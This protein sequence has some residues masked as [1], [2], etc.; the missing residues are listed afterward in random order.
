MALPP[1]SIDDALAEAER[2]CAAGADKEAAAVYKAILEKF[3]QDKRARAGLAA[4]LQRREG[5]DA[6]SNELNTL[7][8]LFNEGKLQTVIERGKQLAAVYPKAARLHNILGAAYAAMG[9]DDEAIKS[10]AKAVAIDPGLAI[11]HN[12]LGNALAKAGRAEDALASYDKAAQLIPQFA[13]AHNN[14]GAALRSLG[15]LDDALSRFAQAIRLKPDYAEAHYNRGVVFASCD[16]LQDAAASFQSALRLSPAFS[17][18][19]NDLGL[20]MDRLGRHEEARANYEKAVRHDRNFAEAHNNLANAFHNAGR[21]SDAIISFSTAVSLAPER[22]AIWQN[23]AKALSAVSFDDYVPEIAEAF[24][25]ILKRKTLIRP[26]QIVRQVL[27][28]LSH[29]PELKDVLSA[30]APVAAA[31]TLSGIPLLLQIMADCPLPDLRFEALLR[32]LRKDL[33][34]DPPPESERPALAPLQTALSLQCFTNEFI[35]GETEEETKAITRLEVAIEETATSGHLPALYDV[36]CLASYRRLDDYEWVSMFAREDALKPVYQ[37]C[38]AEPAEEKAIKPCIATLKEASNEVSIAVQQQYERNP[39]PRWVQTGLRVTPAPV[40]A[41]AQYLKLRLQPGVSLAES[42]DILIAGCGAG[43]HALSTARRFQ[44][45][46]VLAID[47]SRTSLS[48]AKRKSEELGVQNIDYLQ[49]DILDLG[50]LG[51]SFDMIECVGVLHHMRSPFA[52]WKHLSDCLRPGGLMKIG[53]YSERAR[54]HIERVRQSVTLLES[55]AS[56]EAL[57]NR[58]QEIIA[59]DTDDARKLFRSFDFYSVSTFRDLMYHVQEHRFALPQIKADIDALGLSFAGFEFDN[60]G[61]LALFA[62][63]HAAADAI[64]D[65][66]AWDAFEMANPMVFGGMYN[67]WLQKPAA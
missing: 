61:V 15:R 41:I 29:H 23:Y 8:A 21:H 30:P 62:G 43:Q 11:A 50:D 52:G 48:Y 55:A 3:P 31:K 53:L 22:D 66:D 42:P 20:V 16:R 51:K 46:N 1:F 45:C 64:Y 38:V 49:A 56:H 10:Y 40:S 47:L 39:Y 7:I 35:Y 37:R 4:V 25:E 27:G 36:L 24:M 57:L 18:A 67:F 2:L 19:C 13:E 34:I 6:P 12:N 58:R 14:A 26:H 54:S 59:L 32:Q 65:L 5:L 44:D 9:H 17:R 28:L 60:D 63:Q 33:L